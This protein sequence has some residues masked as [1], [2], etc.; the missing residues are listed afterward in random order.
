VEIKP[1]LRRGKIVIDATGRA[2]TVWFILAW[3][4]ISGATTAGV[5][6]VL[7]LHGWWIVLF[8]GSITS[9]GV[10]IT[11]AIMERR[12][13]QLRIAGHRELARQ[14]RILTNLHAEYLLTESAPPPRIQAKTEPLPKEWVEG[15]LTEMGE[16][17]RWT[18]YLPK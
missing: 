17:W 12:G 8:M 1:F 10:G 3:L 7:H 2:I 16:Y 13:W 4:G 15:R 14:H 11:G 6:S 5:H 18:Q 9:I